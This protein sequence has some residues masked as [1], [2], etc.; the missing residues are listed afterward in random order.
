MEPE[1]DTVVQGV[2]GTGEDRVDSVDDEPLMYST[3][4]KVGWDFYKTGSGGGADV[5]DPEV[6]ARMRAALDLYFPNTD[7]SKRAECAARMRR[8]WKVSGRT[9][10]PGQTAL[11][12]RVAGYK[13]SLAPYNP[14][15]I[16]EEP[17]P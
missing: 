5:P 17:A 13:S 1:G 14:M 7:A 15:P 2:R 12:Q 16:P 11:N 6:E 10:L 4:A 3:A 8:W 9:G